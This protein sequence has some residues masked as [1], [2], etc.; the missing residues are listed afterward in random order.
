MTLPI[1]EGPGAQGLSERVPRMR[2][3]GPSYYDRYSRLVARDSKRC[4]KCQVPDGPFEIHH[5][6]GD[7]WNNALWN[8]ELRCA[9]CNTGENNRLRTKKDNTG[10]PGVG[11]REGGGGV[12]ARKQIGLN[13]ITVTADSVPYGSYEARKNAE[14]QEPFRA[15]VIGK[16]AFNG[17][18]GIDSE[19]F[20]EEGAEVFKVMQVTSD[21]YLR[22]LVAPSGPCYTEQVEVYHRLRRFVFL[23]TA[24]WK[25]AGTNVQGKA[26]EMS[27]EVVV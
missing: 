9:P 2:L 21:R 14:A 23:K 1:S 27:G 17:G 18:G 8:L 13:A 22:K 24:F 16:L 7:T 15:W 12:G 5:R 20:V 25:Q 4:F 10:G 6:D 26:P 11:E 19:Y 3:R